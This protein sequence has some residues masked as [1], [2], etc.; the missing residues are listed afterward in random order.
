MTQL[1]DL[2]KWSLTFTKK[3][4]LLVTF[5]W[6]I[7]LIFSAILI[8]YAVQTQGNFS[9]LDT[10][11]TDNGETF[12]LIVGVNIVSKTIENIFKYNEG[13]LFGKSISTETQENNFSEVTDFEENN[14]EYIKPLKGKDLKLSIDVNILSTLFTKITSL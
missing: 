1:K 11:I 8:W 7:Q 3:V 5:I 14:E 9:F 4:I 2:F 13:G 6:T 10:F 12:R